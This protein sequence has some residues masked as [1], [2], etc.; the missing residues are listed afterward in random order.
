MFTTF[1]DRDD[2][3]DD[4]NLLITRR[5][6]CTAL[7]PFSEHLTRGRS[8]SRW[9]IPRKSFPPG[10]NFFLVFALGRHGYR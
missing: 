7:D 4:D 9:R 2:D 8:V 1:R 6:V 10:R 5:V 3:D